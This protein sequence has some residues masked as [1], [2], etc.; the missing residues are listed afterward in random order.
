MPHPM[1]SISMFCLQTKYPQIDVF[2]FHPP[3]TKPRNKNEINNEIL[4][5]IYSKRNNDVTYLTAMPIAF[6]RIAR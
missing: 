3:I 4:G 1:L 5:A 6:F 2:V